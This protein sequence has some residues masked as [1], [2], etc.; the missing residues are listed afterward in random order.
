MTGPK[1]INRRMVKLSFVDA[2]GID[3]GYERIGCKK[4][5]LETAP[6]P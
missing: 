4:N 6:T 2:W 3:R 5:S 1:K